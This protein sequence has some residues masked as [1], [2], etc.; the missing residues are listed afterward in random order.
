MRRLRRGP[1]AVAAACRAAC[2]GA[3]PA[4]AEASEPGIL[5][6]VDVYHDSL[7]HL[8]PARLEG[9]HEFDPIIGDNSGARIVA[10]PAKPATWSAMAAWI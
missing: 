1:T 8:R 10:D 2:V 9:R 7:W 6:D 5:R 3:R 4:S